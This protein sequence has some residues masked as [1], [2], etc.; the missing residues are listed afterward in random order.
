MS[1]VSAP[2]R[3]EGP[4]LELSVFYRRVFSMPARIS[5][6]Q[7]VYEQLLRSSDYGIPLSNPHPGS[8]ANRVN[9]GDVGY[10]Y[11]GQFWRIFNVLK[12]DEKY[13]GDSKPL[14]IRPDDIVRPPQI[15]EPIMSTGISCSAEV[16][17]ETQ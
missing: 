17:S 10:I 5:A 2:T 16:D 11:N 8:P 12:M 14:S 1:T 3:Y 13:C 9:I 15:F 6:S 4:Y 7:S